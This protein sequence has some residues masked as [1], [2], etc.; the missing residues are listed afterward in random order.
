MS[1][2]T[3]KA[4]IGRLT[5]TIAIS[6]GLNELSTI[7]LTMDSGIQPMIEVALIMNEMV[8]IAVM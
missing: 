3:F 4:M 2:A 7:I 5:R 8:I 1:R 6:N